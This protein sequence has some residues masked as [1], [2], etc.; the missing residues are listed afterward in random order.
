[1]PALGLQKIN[2]TQ[3]DKLTLQDLSSLQISLR[4]T[5]TQNQEA[6]SGLLKQ[7]LQNALLYLERNR[8]GQKLS[9]FEENN[10][11]L[12]ISEL[13][14]KLNLKTLPRRI[15]CYDISHLSGKFVYGSMVV[16]I[17]GKP[18]KKFYKLFKTKEQNNDF[19]NHQEVLSRRFNHLLKLLQSEAVNEK[20]ILAWS[21]PNLIIVDGGK[22]Q[23]SADLEIT[24]TYSKI[25]EENNLKFNVELCALAKKEEEVFLPDTEKSVL[26]EGSSRFLI[27]RIRDEAHRFAIT[28]NRNA[29]LKTASKSQLDE[30]I[31]IGA[32][33]KQKILTY[34]GS[35]KNLLDTLT[36][37]KEL[38]YEVLGKNQVERLKKHFGL[39]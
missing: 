26:F 35:T 22:G 29:R 33:T 34:F 13:Q 15:E 1:M 4:N 27:Q 30:V 19:A 23:L 36:N 2:L 18:S 38:A 7:G 28:N 12:A 11:F 20:E 25:F 17:D 39:F 6:I 10:L 9:L 32:K 21:L 8:L 16:F 5:N 3:D 14:K 31:G 37:N 24:N